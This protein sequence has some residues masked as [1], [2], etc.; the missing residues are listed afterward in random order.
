[1]LKDVDIFI[2]SSWFL[3][4]YISFAHWLCCFHSYSAFMEFLQSHSGVIPTCKWDPISFLH[5]ISLSVA[6]YLSRIK[7]KLLGKNKW[8]FITGPLWCGGV[9]PTIMHAPHACYP[10]LPVR[11]QHSS[12]T[13]LFSLVKHC[14]TALLCSQCQFLLCTHGDLLVILQDT[15]QESPSLE[16]FS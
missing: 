14:A 8:P 2:L 13:K 1:M 16:G 4:Y 10:K 11:I 5:K 9:S 15:T 7:L 3:N 6:L 12:S